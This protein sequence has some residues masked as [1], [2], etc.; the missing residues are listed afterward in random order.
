MLMSLTLPLHFV[1]IPHAKLQPD[2]FS[3][4]TIQELFQIARHVGPK[5][6]SLDPLPSPLFASQFDIVLPVL[7]N[8]VNLCLESRHFPRSLKSAVL[9]TLLKKPSLIHEL[10]LNFRAISNFKV[11]S[12]II[13]VVASRL[14][15]LGLI[16]SM[17]RCNPAKN[18]LF[19]SCETALVRVHND[20]L[21]AVN[22][23]SC[24]VQ[25]L[26]DLS[27]AFDTRL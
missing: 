7:Y 14:N 10:L 13:E 15:Y 1:F 22:N 2:N 17:K 18:A 19:H 12:E 23:R 27:A 6:C 11:V 8:I 9:A 24:V 4:T 16:T 3:P 26:L 21:C 20:L 25:P 5:S